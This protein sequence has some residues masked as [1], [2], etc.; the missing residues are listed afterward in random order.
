MR[1]I[2][3]RRHFRTA[4]NI[5]LTLAFILFFET[6][7]ESFAPNV[8][9]LI[10]SGIE[11]AFGK[12]FKLSIADLDGGIL[13][14]FVLNDVRMAGGGRAGLLSSL[15]IRSLTSNYRIWD[16]LFKGRERKSLDGIYIN[17]A[18]ASSGIAGA[19]RLKGDIDNADFKGYL[20][21]PDNR[22]LDFSGN[23]KGNTFTIKLSPSR[24][25]EPFNMTENSLVLLEGTFN[26]DGSISTNVVLNHIKIGDFDIVLLAALKN[27]VKEDTLKGRRYVEGDLETKNFILNYAPFLNLKASYRVYEDVLD[28]TDVGIGD[29][30]KAYGK[31][32]LRSPHKINL[33]CTADNVSLN[34]VLTVNEPGTALLSGIM[35]GKFEMSGP[36][37]RLK[38][39]AHIEVKNGRL[40]DVDFELLSAD[41]KGE[42]PTLHIQDSRIT[43]R[44]GYFALAG[45]IDLSRIGRGPAAFRDVK[46]ATDD[47]AIIWDG[48]EAE[49]VRGINEIKMKKKMSEE[50]DIG[51]KKFVASEKIDESV[52]DKDEFEIDYNIHPNQKL[53]FMTGGDK[54]FFGLEHSD[55]F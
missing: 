11:D 18:V 42:G 54:A 34:K 46:M 49:K 14:P 7:V 2:R 4:L 3:V 24:G 36:I 15:E 55:R 30:F 32:G 40:A 47:Q 53:K 43:R 50:V 37:D 38:S 16:L 26:G 10:E 9:P 28:I 41:L 23:I 19:V 8:K 21:F 33:V 51:F 17:F 1:H 25:L 48:Y 12:R 52:R 27:S 35:N 22:Q 20:T 6:R 5:M 39:S 31:I 29:C 44:S 13:R 45:D